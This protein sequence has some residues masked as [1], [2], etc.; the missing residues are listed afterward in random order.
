M[1][2]GLPLWRGDRVLEVACG[3]GFYARWLASEMAPDGQVVG[4]DRSSEFLEIAQG[5]NDSEGETRDPSWILADLERLPFPD[6][7]FDLVWCAQSLYSLPDPVEALRRMRRVVRPGGVVAVLE[8]DTLHHLLLP[9]P[10]PVELALGRAE[11]L[12]FVERSDDPDK[13]YVARQLG[14]CFQR[15]GL[16]DVRRQSWAS[17]RQAP[18]EPLERAFLALHLADL[19]ERAVPHLEPDV[20]EQ[21]ERLVDPSDDL[22]LLDDPTFTMTCLDHVVWGVNGARR[23]AVPAPGGSAP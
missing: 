3:D 19:R 6:G 5:R 15:A 18:L 9:W 14:E 1:V 11:W 2:A 21:F 10:V 8:N 23:R 22:Y 12:S 7:A 17:N 13:Y 4:I 16:H 20:R